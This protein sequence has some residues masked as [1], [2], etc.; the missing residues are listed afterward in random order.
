MPSLLISHHGA[1]ESQRRWNRAPFLLSLLREG[2]LIS[3]GKAAGFRGSSIHNQ[4]PSGTIDF[5]QFTVKDAGRLSPLGSDAL[6][7]RLFKV[8]PISPFTYP[9]GDVATVLPKPP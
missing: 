1:R 6:E 7:L 2:S 5:H 3:D 9:D 4:L 8:T